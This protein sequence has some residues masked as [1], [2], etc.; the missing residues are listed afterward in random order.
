MEV[1]R[2]GVGNDKYPTID[3]EDFEVLPPYFTF[4]R[5]DVY[6]DSTVK[7]FDEEL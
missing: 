1:K 4:D 3:T 6:F 7:K 2:I 5:E